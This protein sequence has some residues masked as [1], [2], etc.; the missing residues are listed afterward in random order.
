MS[1]LLCDRV[2]RVHNTSRK[3][4][5]ALET[6]SCER[7]IHVTHA[8][9]AVT[10]QVVRRWRETKEEPMTTCKGVPMTWAEPRRSYARLVARGLSEPDFALAE[11]DQTV[12]EIW[13]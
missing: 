3:M 5:N 1:C 13:A 8:M 6:H 9:H 4:S 10:K 7:K 12:A 2:R 11:V